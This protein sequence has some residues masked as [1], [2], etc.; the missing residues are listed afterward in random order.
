M[1]AQRWQLPNVYLMPIAKHH[2]PAEDGDEMDMLTAYVHVANSIAH[3]IGLGFEPN[4][5]NHCP[6]PAIV[7]LLNISEEQYDPIRS[8][9]ARKSPKWAAR[10]ECERRKPRRTRRAQRERDRVIFSFLHLFPSVFSVVYLYSLHGCSV[11][12]E[13]G[14]VFG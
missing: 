11:L 8:A 12:K 9:V 13:Q 4:R 5:T 3:Q 6:N 14:G 2:N 7:A 1:A 10:W